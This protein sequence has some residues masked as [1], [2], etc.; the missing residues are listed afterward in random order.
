[1][2]YY[3]IN[4]KE[5]LMHAPTMK[6]MRK[7]NIKRIHIIKWHNYRDGE[8]LHGFQGLGMEEGRRWS[9]RGN[10]RESYCTVHLNILIMLVVT[11]CYACNKIAWSCTHKDE[12]CITC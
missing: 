4:A 1:M 8:E 2:E 6:C 12:A 11:L 3:S 9:H 5:F 7:I 10:S